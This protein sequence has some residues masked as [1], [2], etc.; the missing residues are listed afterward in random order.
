M[1]I[2][3]AEPATEVID[4]VTTS[5]TSRPISSGASGPFGTPLPSSVSAI[6]IPISMEVITTSTS[7]ACQM[8]SDAAG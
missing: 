1:I 2:C 3:C 8:L 5:A 7:A 4:N 6:I